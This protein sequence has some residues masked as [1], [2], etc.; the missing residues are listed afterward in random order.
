MMKKETKV[1]RM[2][3]TVEK[4]RTDFKKLM[5]LNPNYFGNFPKPPFKAVKKIV[6]N[7]KYEKLT[8]LGFNP[9][10]NMLEA[11]VQINLPYGYGGNLCKLGTTE[12]VR[13]FIDYGDGW[14]N[15]GLATFNV[16]DIPDSDDCADMPNKPLSYVV[17]I[18]LE[19]KRDFCGNPV[20]PKVRAILSW[21]VEPPENNPYWSMVWGNTLECHI[22]I[23]PRLWLLADVVKVIGIDLKQK[24]KLPPIFEEVEPC[25]IPQPEPPP[26]TLSDLVKL[27]VIPVGKKTHAAMVSVE[28]HRF[29]FKEIHAQMA[30]GSVNPQ[31]ISETIGKW[32]ALDLNWSAAVEALQA[33]SGN[34]SYEEL[35]CL[36]LDYN[37]EWLVATFYIKKTS[38]YSGNLCSNGSKEYISFWADWDDTCE[39]TYLD[40]VEVNVY[41]IASIPADGLHYTAILPVDLHTLRQPCNKPKIA[42]VRAVLSWNAP[43]SNT[44]PDDIPYWGNRLDT[45]VQIKPGKP[46]EPKA[47]ISIIGGI[48][49]AD[50]NTVGN[51][52]TKP[53]AKFAEWGSFADPWGTHMR[54][55]PFGGLVTVHALPCVGDKYCIEVREFGSSDTT[56]I[57]NPI[58]VVDWKG[59]GS[60]NYADPV[61]GCF[62]YLDVTQNVLN[63]LA[64]WYT[65]GNGLWEIRLRRYNSAGVWQ[66]DTPWYR[67]RLDNTVPDAQIMIDGG[68]CDKYA[69][70]AVITGKFVARDPYFGYFVLDTLPISMVPTNPKTPDKNGV[71]SGDSQTALTG[72]TW[73]LD[74]KNMKPCGYV[75][76]VRVWDRTVRNS[77]IGHHNWN[78]DDKG[79]CLLEE[80]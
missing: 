2:E 23:K 7:T 50:I 19:P 62:D 59:Q 26:L 52:M 74:T 71:S 45:H 17:T 70:G 61:T 25:P 11:T 79:F 51:G 68:A 55:C 34:V 73:E 42:R 58:Y 30:A 57:K 22:Q 20:L 3:L 10:L 78:V 77:A 49:I 4:E 35:N 64:Q 41:D 32:D 60:Y 21:E 65:S 13:F 63:K 39:W 36:G 43:P 67:I 80:V 27:Y 66:D 69:P 44:D 28:P 38:G 16:H 56:R 14:K 31:M 24:V 37:N 48:G 33:T 76:R 54:A 15:A 40:T 18:P 5:L 6:G 72:N 29:G 53:Q 9:N 47:Q 8:C 1:K 75:V 46:W 12:Y